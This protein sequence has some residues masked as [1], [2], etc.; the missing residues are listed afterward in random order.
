MAQ[1][2]FT[3]D[4]AEKERIDAM[5]PELGRFYS[6]LVNECYVLHLQWAEFKELFGTSPER[7]DVLNQ[8][9]PDFF[10]MVQDR[11][12]EASLL[13]IARLTDAVSTFGKKGKENVTLLALPPLVDPSI[14]TTVKTLVDAAQHECE[15]ARD[16][17]NRRIAHRDLEL[18]QKRSAAPLASASVACVKISLEAIANALNAVELHYLGA[19]VAFDW[20]E[21]ARGATALLHY[22]E[23]GIEA[24]EKRGE[25]LRSGKLL[26]KDVR[27]RRKS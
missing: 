8:T 5:G 2:F 16:W 10:W 6:L 7:I 23:Q 1:T 19:T 9:A 3:A 14:L 17:R 20:I 12:W 4:D 27:P 11:L 24:E 21:S 18:A 15:F 13:H 26:P 22:L 25:R